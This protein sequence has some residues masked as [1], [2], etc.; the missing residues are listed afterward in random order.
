VVC[1]CS[2]VAFAQQSYPLRYRQWEVSGFAGGSF[3]S[4]ESEFPTQVTDNGQV[5]GVR[6]V[7]LHWGSGGQIGFRLGENLGEY[8]TANLEYSFA[9]QPATLTNLSPTVQSLTLSQSVNHFSYGFSYTPAN[10][11]RRF[12]PYGEFGTGAT[13]YFL[14]GSSTDAAL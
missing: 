2:Q 12:R 4:A 7:G 11:S 5:T 6:T 1:I 3:M 8:W 14:R 13:L 9:N 10:R